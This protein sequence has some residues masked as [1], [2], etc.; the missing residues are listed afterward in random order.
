MRAYKERPIFKPGKDPFAARFSEQGSWPLLRGAVTTL[1]VNVGKFCNQTC[2][3]CHVGAGPLRKER[4]SQASA[5]KVVALLERSPGVATVDFTGGA[6]ELHRVFRGLVREC[7]RLGK[8]IIDRC[9]LTVLTLP[10]QK[11]LAEFLAQ[12][13]VEVVASLPC[14]TSDNVEKQRGGGV[15]EKSIEALRL[16]NSLGYGAA[17]SG[18]QLHLV[19]NPLGAFLP[20]S[21]EKLEQEYK[22]QLGEMFSVRFNHLYTLVNMPIS[23]F[24]EYLHH[25]NEYSRYMGLLV[26][27]FNAETLEG[28]MCRSMV[29]VGW[30]GRLYDC[31]FNQM[32]EIPLVQEAAASLDS[33]NSLTHLE[34]LPIATAE[35]CFGCTAGCGSSCTGVIDR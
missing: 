17:D 35:H 15:F 24:A 2:H 21:Q 13:E 26:N 29:S 18:L 10:A 30:D 3:H 11:D 23:R 16:L 4:M 9:N 6:P 31:D 22:R 27:H 5:E 8:K 20:P 33:V 14:Y 12:H 1:Q 7:R 28:L 19:Y 25:R 34:G 32:L